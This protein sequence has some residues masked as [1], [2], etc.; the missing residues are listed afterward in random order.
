M[1]AN[2]FL[3]PVSDADTIAAIAT[4]LGPAGVG[5]VRI[6]GPEAFVIA[7]RVLRPKQPITRA[8]NHLLRYARFYDP[9][10]GEVLDDGL[11]AIF[12]L[13]RSFTGENVVELQGH[14]GV[15]NIKRLFAACLRAGARAARPG[16]FSERAFANGKLDLAQAEAV[17][18]LVS[19]GTEAARRAA[20]RQLGGELSRRVADCRNAVSEALAQIEASIDFPEEVGDIAP[21]RLDAPLAQGEAILTELLSGAVYGRRLTE[22]V[23]VVLTGRPNVGKSSLL[24][25]LAGTERAIVTDIPGTTRDVLEEAVS[26]C[27]IPVRALDTAGLRETAD[28]VERIGVERARQ[29]VQTADVVVVVLDAQ[30]GVT[31]EDRT[32]LDSLQ[33]RAFVVAINKSDVADPAPTLAQLEASL[34]AVPVAARTGAGLSDLAQAIANAATEGQTQSDPLVTSARHEHALQTALD[35]IRRARETLAFGLPP[36]L[37][38]VD[39]HA[40]LQSLGEIT[41]E[42]AR[43][44]IIAEIFSRFC[45]GK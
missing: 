2:A 27:G 17:A 1:P 36:E 11:V 16:E 10:T 41:G 6:S 20:R 24:N 23:T 43:E 31:N 25:A 26:V 8:N 29:A 14:G 9:D 18:A 19:A 7:D 35:S 12:S 33:H 15:V 4:A 45:I 13:P 39:G 34:P 30:T 32:F 3:P 44:D 22:G 28:P 21:L 40:A 37:I 38:A 42:T 5:V